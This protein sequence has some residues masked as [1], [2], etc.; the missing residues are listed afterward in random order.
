MNH[1][2]PK[3][4]EGIRC[5]AISNFAPSPTQA[6]EVALSVKRCGGGQGYPGGG[7]ER[8]PVGGPSGSFLEYQTTP[9][10]YP[11]L[12]RCKNDFRSCELSR[13]CPRPDLNQHAVAGNRF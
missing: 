4:T 6:G 13:W 7:N 9:R 10:A 1:D 8:G 12:T 5:I 3:S 11:V 2:P